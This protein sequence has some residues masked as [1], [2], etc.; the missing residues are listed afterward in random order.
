M[1]YISFAEIEKR[2]KKTDTQKIDA[3]MV[4]GFRALKKKKTKKIELDHC[5]SSLLCLHTP[6]G[7]YGRM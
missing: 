5:G 6:C 4:G 3:A 2:K 1:T 7:F